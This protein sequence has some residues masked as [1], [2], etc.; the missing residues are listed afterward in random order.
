VIIFEFGRNEIFVIGLFVFAFAH[1]FIE[2]DVAS[3][4]VVLF[5]VPGQG[6]DWALIVPYTFAVGNDWVLL[7]ATG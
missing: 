1:D 6:Q 5:K 3:V 2:G 7:A 4:K